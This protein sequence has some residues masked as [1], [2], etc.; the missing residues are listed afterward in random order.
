MNPVLLLDPDVLAE[1][2]AIPA[3]EVIRP[4]LDVSTAVANAIALV[5]ELRPKTAVQ[6]AKCAGSLTRLERNAVTLEQCDVRLK[7][8]RRGSFPDR[9]S[10][11][12]A[13]KLRRLLYA[14]VRLLA[15]IGVLSPERWTARRARTGCSHVARD[16]QVLS[17]TLDCFWEQ[18]HQHGFVYRPELVRA[19]RLSFELTPRYS[20]EQVRMVADARDRAFT[21]LR[22]TYNELRSS[23]RF[24]FGKETSADLL[25]PSL[26]ARRGNAS[27]T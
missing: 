15:K 13:V 7:F 6:E 9:G 1:L 12:E 18:V 21:L 5:R 20:K 8:V 11:A 14:N 3:E 26:Y 25:A 2:N 19:E 27:G 16:L 24:H 10:L 4:N 22:K 23:L 17:F